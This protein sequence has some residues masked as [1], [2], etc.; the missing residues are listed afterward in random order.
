[1][2]QLLH[3]F[4][5]LEP[6]MEELTPLGYHLAQLPVSI[7]I[8]KL[9]IYGKQIIIAHNCVDLFIFFSQDSSPFT[10]THVWEMCPHENRNIVCAN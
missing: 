7:H 9:L 8:G 4:K 6:V 3:D 5:A 1:M 2:P 10:F